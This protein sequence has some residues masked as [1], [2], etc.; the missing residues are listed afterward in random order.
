MAWIFW[1]LITKRRIIALKNER[2]CR[3]MALLCWKG[4]ALLC[5]HYARCS[6][7]SIMLELWRHNVSIPTICTL[8]TKTVGCFVNLGITITDVMVVVIS[9][10][11]FFFL[12]SIIKT[13]TLNITFVIVIIDRWASNCFYSIWPMPKRQLQAS[14]FYRPICGKH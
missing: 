11:H 6:T 3:K 13:T 10:T 4:I 1:A 8:S 2:L 12:L 5:R 9:T 14:K 7:Y